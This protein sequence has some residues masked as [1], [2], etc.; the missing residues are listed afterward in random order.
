MNTSLRN[1]IKIPLIGALFLVLMTSVFG[2]GFG[3]AYILTGAGVLPWPQASPSPT[4]PLVKLPGLLP[5]EH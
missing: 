3:S 2:A 5:T 1:I 4:Q